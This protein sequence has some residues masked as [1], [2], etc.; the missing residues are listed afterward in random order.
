MQPSPLCDIFLNA[1]LGLDIDL[2]QQSAGVARILQHMGNGAELDWR[3]LL[4]LAKDVKLDASQRAA[5][6]SGLSHKVSLIQGPPGEYQTPLWL[7]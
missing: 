2:N 6:I 7:S 4:Q 1:D 3:R 5:L